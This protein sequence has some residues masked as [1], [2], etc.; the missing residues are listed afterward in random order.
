[1]SLLELDHVVIAAA[2][3]ETAAQ[4]LETQLGLASVEGG[5]HP[6]LGT[7]NRI[8]PLGETYLE[9]IAIVDAAKAEQSVPGRWVASAHS[10]RPLGWAVRTRDL[11]NVAR[12]LDLPVSAGSRATPDG[13]VLRWRS[14][15]LEQSVAEPTLPFFIEWDTGTPFPG[16]AR[17]PHPAGPVELA[18]LKL[19]GDRQRLAAWLGD[20]HLPITVQEGKPSLAG[21]VL[22]S[23]AGEIVLGAA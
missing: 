21:V 14:A 13:E 8:V 2:D 1:V 9:L 11:D 20:H 22:T 4:D 10:G 3:L 15:G 23:P 12:R 19:E 5:R 17:M 16:R 7:A 6:D 18:R